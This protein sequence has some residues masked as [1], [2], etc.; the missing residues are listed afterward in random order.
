MIGIDTNVLARYYI[1]D[2]SDQQA[3]SIKRSEPIIFICFGVVLNLSLIVIFHRKNVGH[4][5]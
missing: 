4:K 2:E 3:Q 5:L 1:R